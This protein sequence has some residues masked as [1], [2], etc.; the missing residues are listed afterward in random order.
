MPLK[1]L[2]LNLCTTWT[3]PRKKRLKM[4][5]DFVNANG[6]D[7][8]LVQEGVRS[9]LVYD[10]I[11]QLAG[12][13]DYD[14]FAKASWGFP[15]FF[16]SMTAV[17]SRFKIIRT[18]SFSCEVPQTD[19]EDAMPIPWR[20]RAVSATVDVPDLG[21]TTL[22]SVH[23]T[24]SP[25]TVADKAKQL[26]MVSDWKAGLPERDV[27]I[28]GGD[29]NTSFDGEPKDKMFGVEPDYIFVEGATLAKGY[30]VLTGMVVTDH[31]GGVVAEVTK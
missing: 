28:Y 12:L 13:L 4:V 22:V 9:C 6:I 11:R 29:F 16:E 24:S 2:T 3:S 15:F 14:Y 5:A 19:W 25:K 1:V 21:I 7:V 18:A 30:Q 8:L 26:K 31:E 10:T 23:L 17:I 27:T 20:A